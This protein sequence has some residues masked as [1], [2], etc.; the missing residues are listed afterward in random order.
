VK[1]TQAFRIFLVLLALLAF[2][3][4]D[5]KLI[6]IDLNAATI[7]IQQQNSLK[8]I[9]FSPFTEISING[10]KAT[11]AQLKPG[12]LVTVGLADPQN[13]TKIAVRGNPGAG[14]A[15]TPTGPTPGAAFTGFASTQMTRRIVIKALVDARDHWTIQDGKL[16]IEHFE[17]KKPVDIVIN[18]VKWIPNWTG[19]TTDDFTGFTPPLAPFSAGNL[20]IKKTKGR[21]EVTILEP[22]TEANG[23]KFVFR[24]QD[25]GAGAD[26]H[27]V[28]ITW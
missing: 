13:A 16:R 23:Y 4:G 21:G 27:E 18:G 14:S 17:F 8:T 1:T 5:D 19:N 22:P 3:R 15:S 25:K 12:M 24:L 7:I 28:R 9:H 6:A 10:V 20:T 26:E 2:A 11:S